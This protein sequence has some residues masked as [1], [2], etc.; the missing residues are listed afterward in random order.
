MIGHMCLP[1]T[2]TLG[3]GCFSRKSAG[4]ERPPISFIKGAFKKAGKLVK[5]MSVDD[6]D[7]ANLLTLCALHDRETQKYG[8]SFY[9]WYTFPVAAILAVEWDAVRSPINVP[10]KPA[11]SNPWHCDVV[12]PDPLEAEDELIDKSTK[13]ASESDWY[14]RP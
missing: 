5:E 14:Q 12:R 2:T 6:L 13:I 8:K 7:S 9:G 11:L 10:N 3:R 4:R 1:T